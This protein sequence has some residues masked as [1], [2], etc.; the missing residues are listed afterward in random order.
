M[1]EVESEKVRRQNQ[2]VDDI[3]GKENNRGLKRTMLSSGE[4][5]LDSGSESDEE[6]M[7][8]EPQEKLGFGAKIL[9]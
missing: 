3:I 8:D 9:N 2:L 5:V 6:L 7:L 1:N 4:L